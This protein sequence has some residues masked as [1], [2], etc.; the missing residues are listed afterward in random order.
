MYSVVIN[1]AIKHTT[2]ELS[3]SI[4]TRIEKYLE[5]K[6]QAKVAEAS[7]KDIRAYFSENLDVI[8]EARGL[9]DSILLEQLDIL[10][11]GK[12]CRKERNTRVCNFDALK[13]A[14][15]AL[16]A[17]VVSISNSKYIEIRAVSR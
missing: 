1:S 15:Q 17:Q 8:V 16:Y 11:N 9:E 5:L 4:K 3:M 2:K 10:Q 14:D 6:K 13:E 12:V 7:M